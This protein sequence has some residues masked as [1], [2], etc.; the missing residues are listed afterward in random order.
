[1]QDSI[2]HLIGLDDNDLGLSYADNIDNNA[3]PDDPYALEYP[4][5]YGADVNSPLITEE[6][7]AAA[8]TDEWN[9]YAV[10]NSNIIL[11]DVNTE[12]LGKPY[13]DGIDKDQWR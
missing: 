1:M 11:Y 13:A 2:I 8:A 6:I 12:D 7:I 9:R 4:Y 5:G 3:N 10:P